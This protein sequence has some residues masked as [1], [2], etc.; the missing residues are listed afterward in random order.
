MKRETVNYTLVGVVV[1]AALV[2]LLVALTTITG[3]G[4]ASSS[5]FVR[6]RNVTGL[7][8]GAPVFYE[9]F[10]IGQV[11]AIEPERA[12]G[13]TTYKVELAVRRDWTIPAD[14]VARLAS[15]GLLADV[16]I[17][18]REGSAPERLPPGAE[19]RG[20]EGAD[21][22]AAL[23]EL[24]S[25]VTTLTRTRITPLVET[26]S[27]RVGSITATVDAQTPILLGEAQTLLERLNAAAVSVNDV[28]GPTNRDH[29]AATLA[30]VEA[31]TAE[32]KVT[33]A[34]LDALLE[35]VQGI[36]AENRPLV[37]ETL[38]DLAQITGAMARRIDSIAH[39]IE[40]S[41]RNFDEFTREI[42]KH[43]NRLLITPDADDVVVEEEKRK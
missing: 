24:A 11:E 36:A 8:Y 19:I 40:S 3:K 4:G 35:D 41:S 33:Q 13:R 20:E 38:R 26:L 34:R 16:A 10:R 39:N 30:N 27:T 32:L 9:G 5:Y 1:L 29:L 28:L 25:E 12:Q 14:S 7:T 23:N 31:V 43:P 15:S 2:A 22:F 21:V 18:I 42:R 17:A 37:R 6:Y